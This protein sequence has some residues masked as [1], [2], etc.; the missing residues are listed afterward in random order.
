MTSSRGQPGDVTRRAVVDGRG[1]ESVRVIIV[2]DIRLYREGLAE[3]LGR[4]DRVE[5]VA[6]VTD[7]RE[8]TAVLDAEPVPIVVLGLTGGRITEAGA[9]IALAHPDSQIVA[10][11]VED[12]SVEDVVSLAE[13][14]IC[15]YV[16][17]D[18]S[19]EDLVATLE[20]VSRGEMPCSPVVAGGL[21]RRLS[22]LALYARPPALEA[23]LTY[24]EREVLNLVDEG[25]SNKE[26]ASHLSIQVATVKNHVH[27]V[28]D[29]LQVR[30]RSEAAAVMRRGRWT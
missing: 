25:L 28:L 5:V 27:S 6:S 10:L 3:A 30:R 4:S 18:G 23:R 16:G 29:K 14:G 13:A 17:R 1:V 26:I 21:V 24:R 11:A 2:A 20:S 7:P 15:G 9:A 19:L 12:D 22:A 8:A